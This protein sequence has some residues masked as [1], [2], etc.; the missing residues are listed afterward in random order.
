MQIENPSLV[1]IHPSAVIGEDVVIHPFVKIERGV[2]IGDHCE[3]HSFVSLRE[4]TRLGNNNQ[5]FEGCV[6][7]AV[8]QDH[9]RQVESMGEVHIGNGNIFREH[10]VINRSLSTDHVTRVGDQ[11]FLM[12]GVHLA[13]DVELGN[14]N[15]VGFGSKLI[16][17]C[18]VADDVFIG[19]LSVLNKGCH[20]GRL[21]FLSTRSIIYKHVPPFVRIGGPRGEWQGVNTSILKDNHFSERDIKQILYAYR[22]IY[23]PYSLDYI[24]FKIGE[25]ATGCPA[26][27]EIIEFARTHLDLGLSGKEEPDSKS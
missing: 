4:G 13:H 8:P 7:G 22:L 10:V 17:D 2:V 14:R 23:S 12:E 26:V 20:V 18:R 11:N 25:L 3:I 6:I 15:V 16:P 9:A 1:Y 5:I 21:S 27:S 24:R 19:A